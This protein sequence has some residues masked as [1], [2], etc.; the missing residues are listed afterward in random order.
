VNASRLR[1]AVTGDTAAG[2]GKALKGIDAAGLAPTVPPDPLADQVGVEGFAEPGV[3]VQVVV[4]AM[5]WVRADRV[6]R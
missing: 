5:A 3:S 1:G 2:E 4:S 6:A